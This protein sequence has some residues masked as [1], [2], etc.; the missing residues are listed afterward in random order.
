MSKTI[1]V[2]FLAKQTNANNHYL[3]RLIKILNH[4][5]SIEPEKKSKDY[6]YHHI[7][8]KSWKPD[9]KKIKDNI[10]QL[11]IRVHFIIHH[12]YALSFPS[13]KSMTFAFW[14]MINQKRNGKINSRLYFLIRSEYKKNISN[15]LKGRISPIKGIKKKPRSPEHS[16]NISKAKK[17]CSV[18]PET[19]KA[20]SETFS[21]TL[22]ITDGK[23]CKR[24]NKSSPI[25]DG[26]IRG[27]GP[28]SPETKMKRTDKVRMRVLD[29]SHHFLGTVSAFNLITQEIKRISK[30]EFYSNSD[31]WVS[32]FK[33][34]DN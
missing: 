19:K 8:P 31:I 21:N 13:D 3:N 28:Q 26:W 24:I 18:S 30:E 27:R 1:Y 32:T 22:W 6:E 12:L 14:R 17:G 34:I 2:Q 23:T 20:L 25:P 7:V 9:W 33:K 11:P 4:F 29:G 10:V 16:A 15:L 5:I